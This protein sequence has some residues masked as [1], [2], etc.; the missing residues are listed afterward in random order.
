[1]PSESVI[2]VVDDEAAFRRSLIFLLESVGWRVIG[3]ESAESFLAAAPALPE[4]GGCLLLDVRMPCMSGF[5][6]Q[7]RLLA[8]GEPWPIVFMTGHG[9]EEMAAH[10]LRAGACDFLHKPFADQVV[11]DAVERAIR[12]C[13][14]N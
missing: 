6:L 13:R 4:E 2:H 11:L 7:R 9:D 14:V 10:A 1:M 12:Q 5:E 3:H 8:G